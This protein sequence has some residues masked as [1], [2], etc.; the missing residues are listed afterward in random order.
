[1]GRVTPLLRYDYKDIDFLKK[2]IPFFE[3]KE[4]FLWNL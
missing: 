4:Q 2:S 1:M 3:D